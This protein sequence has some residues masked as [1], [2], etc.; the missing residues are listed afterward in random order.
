MFDKEP[1]TYGCEIVKDQYILRINYIK[2]SV[3]LFST[4]YTYYIEKY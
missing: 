3:L 2:F 1:N 4:I